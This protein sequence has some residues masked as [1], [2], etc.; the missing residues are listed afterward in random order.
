V[1]ERKRPVLYVCGPQPKNTSSCRTEHWYEIY[2]KA[3][4]KPGRAL[5]SHHAWY[6]PI[7]ACDQCG[8]LGSAK[9][10]HYRS[11]CDSFTQGKAVMCTSCWN[12]IRPLADMERAT[13]QIKNLTNKLIRENRK[14]NGNQ[15]R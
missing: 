4:G 3:D 5:V 9:R 8:R 7:H 6:T 11:M 10:V 15:N 14:A 13:W 12:R 1:K 2:I